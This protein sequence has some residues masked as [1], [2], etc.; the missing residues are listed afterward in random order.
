MRS[1]TL[2]LLVI[3]LSSIGCSVALPE[4]PHASTPVVAV[5]PGHDE[6]AQDDL[7]EPL[8]PA[9]SRRPEKAVP[10]KEPE[11]GTDYT[12]VCQ[13]FDYRIG[14]RSGVVTI[15]ERWNEPTD[16]VVPVPVLDFDTLANEAKRR[17]DSQHADIPGIPGAPRTECS[18]QGLTLIRVEPY[19]PDLLHP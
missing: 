11:E 4:T 14:W 16:S 17:F 10:P 7:E 5:D 2:S 12:F 6:Q 19:W 3:A 8:D 9:S 15:R 18:F 13:S 1:D